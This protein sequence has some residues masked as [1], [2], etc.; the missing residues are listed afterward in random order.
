MQL[1]QFVTCLLQ[2]NIWILFAAR[3]HQ[4]LHSAAVRRQ[5]V[6]PVPE[7]LQSGGCRPEPAS[8]SFLGYRTNSRLRCPSTSDLSDA[9]RCSA[10]LRDKKL[11]CSGHPLSSLSGGRPPPPPCR[12]ALTYVF[13][14]HVVVEGEAVGGA[15]ADWGRGEKTLGVRVESWGQQTSLVALQP[16]PRRLDVHVETWGT[17]SQGHRSAELQAKHAWKEPPSIFH[18]QDEGSPEPD[19]EL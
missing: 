5:V 4:Y 8:S 15:V 2:S 1:V 14:I 18:V 13:S 3:P 7:R 9:G 11:W 10:F 6:C 19:E 17:G 16:R 12:R